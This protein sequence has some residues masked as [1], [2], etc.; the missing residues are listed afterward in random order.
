MGEFPPYISA[1]NRIEKYFASI[2]KA[3]VPSKFSVDYLKTILGFKSSNDRALI[4]LLKRLKFIGSS[5]VPTESYKQ[6]R[7]DTK[8]KAVMA[9]AIKV[10]FQDL[11]QTNEY[12]HELKESELKELIKQRTGV[13]DNDGKLVMAVG[14]FINL[15]KLADFKHGELPEEPEN[16]NNE[17]DSAPP[18]F[19]SIGKN[20]LG[21]SYTIN[22]NLPAT[23]DIEVFNAI[24]RSLKEHLLQDE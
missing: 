20:N 13:A 22:L 9:A 3:Q 16:E 14:T 15:R 1:Y 6:F 5:N 8:S 4:S 12:V 7:N 18:Q 19:T 17:V 21:I 2:K 10:A 23:T 24:F 11:Y